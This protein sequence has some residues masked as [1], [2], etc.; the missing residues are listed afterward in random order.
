MNLNGVAQIQNDFKDGGY[1]NRFKFNDITIRSNGG[2]TAASGWDPVT[3]MGS[4]N[5]NKSTSFSRTNRA[6]YLLNI[7][8]LLTCFILFF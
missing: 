5:L 1:Y 2:Y 3:G 6:T 7:I 8:L 4:F